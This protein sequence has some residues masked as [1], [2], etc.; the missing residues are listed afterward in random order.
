MRT[1]LTNTVTISLVHGKNTP[2][3]N[4]TKYHTVDFLYRNQLNNSV[5]VANYC[6]N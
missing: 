3:L 4:V 6:L 1:M 2:T 5:L